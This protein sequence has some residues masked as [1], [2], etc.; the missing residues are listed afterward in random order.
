MVRSNK[1]FSALVVC[2]LLIF[3]MM[4]GAE[5][6]P[7]V[8]VGADQLFTKPYHERLRHKN[9]GIITNQ[10]GVDSAMRS[11]IELLKM[12]AK[13]LNYK[14]KAIFAPEHGL[15]GSGYA[16]RDIHDGVD[17]DGITI[18]SLHGKTRRPTE[19]MLKDIDLLIYDIQDLGTRSYT[20]AATLFYAM[21]EAAKYKIPVWVLDRP[22]PINGVTIDGPMLEE[23]LRSMVGY[24]NVPYCHGMTIG[25]LALYFNGEYQVGCQLTVVPMEGWHR[26]MSFDETGLSW[27][28][29]SPQIPEAATAFFYP[30]TG[31]IGELSL[32]S[33]G[34]GYTLPFKLIGA[35]W[36]DASLLARHLN[37]QKFP[38]IHFEPF[39][40]RPFYGKYAKEDC[41]GVLIVLTD[42]KKFKP[43]ATQYLILGAL[44]SLYPK[45]FDEA[46]KK[47]SPGKKIA[48][49]K[50]N[51]TPKVCEIM[52]KDKYI[53]WNL[54]SLDEQKRQNFKKKR[55]KYLIPGYI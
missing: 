32:V 34:V 50:V 40:Y 1:K 5:P 12:H 24:I 28:P 21:E 36:I 54:C 13:S 7:K 20:Y 15:S 25:E 16:Y 52:S 10:T 11:T 43:V 2:M 44:K 39:H 30:I 49:D 48:F 3:P 46:L 9:I 33:T 29:T 18:Y 17:P 6:P 4:G 22:N 45:Q 31:V 26:A 8:K 37:A 53:T 14:L 42:R 35:P 23:G 41:H 51:G 19:E 47:M 55:I 27:V 38:G